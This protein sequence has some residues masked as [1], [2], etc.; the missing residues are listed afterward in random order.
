M[1][2]HYMFSI[3]GQYFQIS[4]SQDCKRYKIGSDDLPVAVDKLVKMFEVPLHASGCVSPAAVSN[5]F[6]LFRASD[7]YSDVWKEFQ[8]A[9]VFDHSD[10]YAYYRKILQSIPDIRPWAM[11]ALFVLVFPTG[12]AIS[13]R[14][15][16][17]MGRAKSKQRSELGND[18]VFAHLIIGFNGPSV[19]DFSTQINTESRQPNWPLYIHP[20]NY[21]M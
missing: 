20:N 5:A 3:W 4:A 12:N 8:A 19:I 7:V 15:F 6:I 10:I 13:E 1:F 16:S 18:Q 9:K 11:F 14:G 2:C 21:N 17:A